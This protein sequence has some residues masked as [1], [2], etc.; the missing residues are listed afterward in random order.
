[1]AVN[2]ASNRIC[3]I[4]TG[5]FLLNLCDYRGLKENREDELQRMKSEISLIDFLAA[6]GFQIDERKSWASGKVMVN[7]DARLTVGRG[8]D[9]NWVWIGRLGA[10]AI[11]DYLQKYEGSRYSNLGECRKELRLW[12]S[13]AVSG[14]P[15]LRHISGHRAHNTR[16]TGRTGILCR[17]DAYTRR[18]SSLSQ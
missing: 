17:Y 5:Q 11:I 1:M 15:A 6:R 12:L 9:R 3:L 14:P 18:N 7:G 16:F 4:K 2:A 8:K 13:G 10:G